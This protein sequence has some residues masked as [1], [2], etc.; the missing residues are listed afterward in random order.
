MADRL[1]VSR[2][3]RTTEKTERLPAWNE[4][5]VALNQ[6]SG[7]DW[8]DV[9]TKLIGDA[10][11]TG[12]AA[13]T[14][15]PDWGDIG[16]SIAGLPR[17]I[18]EGAISTPGNLRELGWTAR[19]LVAMKMGIDPRNVALMDRILGHLPTTQVMRKMP[20]SEQVEP[21][22]ESVL[23]PKYEPTSPAGKTISTIGENALDPTMFIPGGAAVKGGK[24]G[25]KA[26]KGMVR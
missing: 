17:S 8:R 2:E 26:L 22:F 16:S 13:L 24:M 21:A 15:E 20:T 25:L 19:D 1:P 4:D 5:A 3:T 11:T 14:S 18:A 23:G 12:K 9:L 10:Y 7:G 6:L